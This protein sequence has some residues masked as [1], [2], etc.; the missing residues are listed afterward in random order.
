MSAEFRFEITQKIAVLSRNE[1]TDWAKEVNFVS[2]NGKNPRLDIRE[3]SPDHKHCS[4]GVILSYEE[5]V[6]LK[7]ALSEI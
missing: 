4:R 7:Q 5:T 3:W 6:A 1:N 2:W